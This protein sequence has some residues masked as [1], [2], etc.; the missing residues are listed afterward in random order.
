MSSASLGSGTRL[1]MKLRSRPLSRARVSTMLNAASIDYSRRSC[2]G[3]ILGRGDQRFD[4]VRDEPSEVLIAAEVGPPLLA[5]VQRANIRSVRELCAFP[6]FRQ[7]EIEITVGI[8]EEAKSARVDAP[9]RGDSL[10]PAGSAE[11]QV[12]P[13]GLPL[14]H[15]LREKG[16]EAEARFFESMD[17]LEGLA[18]HRLP[19][20]KGCVDK[21]I[22]VAE[23]PVEAAFGH[24]EAAGQS[25]DRQ[26]VEA[27]GGD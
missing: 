9:H 11:G 18:V 12:Q 22:E 21:I 6:R 2:S 10:R 15:R 7:G 26:R 27:A 8:D 1:R 20:M 14:L 4:R 16:D 24:S 5:Q 17:L 25:G 13:M 23:M 19:S 3:N